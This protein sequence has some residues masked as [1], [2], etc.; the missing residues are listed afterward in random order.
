MPNKKEP[1]G[2]DVIVTEFDSWLN[3]NYIELLDLKAGIGVTSIMSK[4]KSLRHREIEKL[5]KK[6]D[7]LME[8]CNKVRDKYNKPSSNSG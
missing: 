2:Q 3:E 8:D 4:W 6:F 7:D 5:L 1:H